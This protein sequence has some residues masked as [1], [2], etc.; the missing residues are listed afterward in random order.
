MRFVRAH[1]SRKPH[2]DDEQ[3]LTKMQMVNGGGSEAFRKENP[4][5]ADEV[6][7]HL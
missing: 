2:S 5:D 3:A 6:S 1:Q 4:T 7:M